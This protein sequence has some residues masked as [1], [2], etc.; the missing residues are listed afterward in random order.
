MKPMKSFFV[1]L[2]APKGQTTEKN[3]NYPKF[4]HVDSF[5]LMKNITFRILFKLLSLLTHFLRTFL[6]LLLMESNLAL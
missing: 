4:N 2:L 1:S 3:N 6:T 5:W